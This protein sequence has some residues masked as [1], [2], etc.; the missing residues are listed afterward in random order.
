[1]N[2][3]DKLLTVILLIKDRPT[4]TRR[5]MH[6]TH[7]TQFPFQILIADGG[8]D[9]ALEKNLKNTSNYPNLNYEYLRYTYDKNKQR[10]L[11]KIMDVLNKVKTPYVILA[12]DDDFWGVEGLRKS[13]LFLEENNDYSTC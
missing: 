9:T 5:W 2:K 1:M 12:D 13:I 3:M 10:Y 4:F 7:S 8:Q 11:L 6:F